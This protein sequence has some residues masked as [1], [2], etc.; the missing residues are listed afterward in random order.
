MYAANSCVGNTDRRCNASAH[1]QADESTCF[2]SCP[3]NQ[4]APM[5]GFV[6]VIDPSRRL[7]AEPSLVR[8]LAALSPRGDR[9][10]V[11][12]SNESVMAV[13]RFDWELADEFSGA[14][15][16]VNDG[17]ISVAADATLYY[18]DDLLRALGGA[19]MRP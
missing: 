10:E 11:W 16:I 3:R 6:A 12:R 1:R 13:A 19:S 17:D 15:L 8:S 14:G 5:S 7:L 9:Y 18:H 4:G 2:A